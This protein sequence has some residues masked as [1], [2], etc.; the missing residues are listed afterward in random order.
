MNILLVAPNAPPKN[1]AESIQVGRF[2]AALDPAVRVTLVTTPIVHG[3]VWQDSTLA[4]DRPGLQVVTPALPF[5]RL[6]QR[7][8]SNRHLSALHVPDADFW[9]PWYAQWLS[10]QLK[11]K[12]DVIYSRSAPFSAAL[13]ARRLKGMFGCP[14]LMHLS[15]PWADNPYRSMPARRAAADHALEAACMADAD[16]I[17]LTTE[18]QA[19]HYRANY[20]D[21][22]SAITVTPNMM[23]LQGDTPP[24]SSPSPSGPLRIVYTGALYG[25]REPSTLLNALRILRDRTPNLA[26]K[27]AVDFF[28][29]MPPDIAVAVSAVPGCT[30][31]GVVSSELALQAQLSADVLLTIEPNGGHPLHLHFMPSKN[32]DYI[33]CG[34][35]ILAITPQGSETARLCA[36]GYG[37][38]IAPGDAEA[39]AEK[40]STLT[41]VYG[42][43]TPQQRPP[44][45]TTSPYRPEAVASS[46]L[47]AL[48][49][50][51]AYGVF[52]EASA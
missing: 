15:D 22:A 32:L 49:G 6:S 43:V 2:L 24:P 41:H 5:H 31:H 13:L 7:I 1:S 36:A 28:G 51:V 20:P 34:K 16:L 44:D 45:L 21:R 26:G 10:R 46:I 52:K 3:W 39:L 37:W 14:W 17:T 25:N 18:G 29:N 23:P 38:A 35:P 4:F 27:I 50:L 48:H 33:A 40:L 12:P 42:T 11:D 9:L 30:H 47:Q 19:A 8:L